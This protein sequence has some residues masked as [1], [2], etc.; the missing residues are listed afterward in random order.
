MDK[1][2]KYSNIVTH[3]EDCLRQYGDTNK[4]VDWP[5]LEDAKKRYKVMLE[6]ISSGK[7]NS[8]LLDFGCGASHLFEYIKE[9][10][11]D[12]IAY[13]GLDISSRFVELSR[14]KYP[15]NTYYCIDLLVDESIPSFDYIV[16]NGVF[17]EKR[18]LS[19]NEMFEYFKELLSKTFEKVNTGLAFNVMCKHVDWERDDLFHLPFDLLADFLVKNLSRNFVFRNDYG[20]Y[21]YTT[22]IYK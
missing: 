10:K 14:K 7:K 16:M 18:D 4:G 8:S 17:T 19:F 20:L 3:Y 1:K 11:M 13:S 22:Y 12:K 15:S 9:N 5:N 21:E 2:K 6:L